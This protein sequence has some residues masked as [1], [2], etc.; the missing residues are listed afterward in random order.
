MIPVKSG[1]IYLRDEKITNLKSHL[2]SQKKIAH[3]PE[4]RK[5][6]SELSIEENLRVGAYNLY[7]DKAA[8]AELLEMNYDLFPIPCRAPK[9]AGGHAFRRGAANASHCP[10]PDE[11]AG[12]RVAGRTESGPRTDHPWKRFFEFIVQINKMG[13]TIFLVEQ[14]AFLALET[15]SYVY[16]L[17][18][19]RVVNQNTSDV[20]LK[21]NAIQKAYLGL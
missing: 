1:D 6:F 12:D 14:N 10:R 4:G 3:V 19:G 15:A 7:K 13:K 9:T 11:R 18:T 8:V 21:D 5:I 17:E 16:V 20:L 2:I